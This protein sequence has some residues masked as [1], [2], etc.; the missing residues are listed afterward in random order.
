MFMRKKNMGILFK[1]KSI[2][3]LRIVSNIDQPYKIK[4]ERKKHS[5]S[6]SFSP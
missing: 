6:T 3:I 4:F 2:T 5:L 1:A